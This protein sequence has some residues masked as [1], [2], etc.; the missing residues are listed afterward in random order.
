MKKGKWNKFVGV[1]LAVSMIMGMVFLP[2]HVPGALAG[3]EDQPLIQR[4]T[5]GALC[6][7]TGREITSNGVGLVSASPIAGGSGSANLTLNIPASASAVQAYLYWEGLDVQG[8]GDNQVTLDGHSITGTQLGDNAFVDTGNFAYAYQA[9]VTSYIVPGNHTY[10][11]GGLDSQSMVY[12]GA[13]LVVVYEDASAGHND[14]QIWA[15]DDLVNE[16]AFNSDDNPITL[17]FEPAAVDRTVHVTFV[18]GGLESSESAKVMYGTGTSAP[19]A[20]TQLATFVGSSEGD[21]WNNYSTSFTLPAG[22]TYATLTLK[23]NTSGS[24]FEWVAAHTSVQSPCPEVE[25]SKSLVTPTD[26]IAVVGEAIQFQIV[27]TNTGIT[28]L[29]TVPL[30]DTYDKNKISFQS[31][32]PAP[33]DTTDDGQLDWSNLGSLDPGQST[34][35]TLN[36]TA[37]GATWPGSTTNAALVSGATDQNNRTAP[38]ASD[39]ATVKVTQPSLTLSKELVSPSNGIANVGESVVFRITV[40]NSDDTTLTTVPLQDTYDSAKLSFQS[41]STSPDSTSSGQLDWDNVG[42]LTGGAS[43]VITVTFTAIASTLPG[44]TTNTASTHNVVD[45]NGDSVSDKTDSANVTITNP[46]YEMSKTLLSPSNGIAN[47]GESVVF[48]ITIHNTGDTT[49]S[50]VKVRDSY[51][52]TKLSFQSA[53]VTPD[54]TNDDGQLDWSNVG[55][56]SPGATKTIDLTFNA[57]AS[58]SST[59]NT[60]TVHDVVDNNGDTLPDRDD[61][62]SVKI[63]HPALTITKEL[64]TPSNGIATVGDAVQFR[65]TIQNTGDTVWQTVPLNDTYDTTYLTYQNSSPASDDN[66]DD[67][68]IDWSNVGPISVGGSKTILVNF[69]AKASTGQGHTTNVALVSGPTDENGDTVQDQEDTADVRVTNPG[70]QLSKVLVS[71]SNGIAT[72][73]ENV[74]F[75]IVI[76]NTGDTDITTLPVRDTYETT[77]LTYQ[78]ADPASDD[79][80]D[81]GQIDWSNVGPLAS[82]ASKTITVTFQ[83][84]A[85]TLPGNTVNNATSH[86]VVDENGAPVPDGSDTEPVTIT[87]PGVEVIKTLVTPASGQTLV[88]D[89]VTFQIV[90]RNTGDTTLTYLPLTDTY[91]PSCL[92]YIAKSASPNENGTGAGAIY[93]NDLTASFGQDL[94][95]GDSFTVTVPFDTVGSCHPATNTATVNGE[96]ENGDSVS[97]T[98]SADV[99]IVAP[100]SIGDYVWNDSN[101]NGLQDDAASLGINGVTVNL[102]NDANGSG[103]IDAG[104]SILSTTTTQNDGSGNP[105]WYKFTHLWPGDYIVQIDSSNFDSGK[106]LHGMELISGS[107]SGPEPY[108]KTL[109][110]GENHVNADFGYAGRGDISGVVYYDWDQSHSQGL[111]EDGI[112]NVQVCLYEDSNNNGSLDA[113]EPQLACQNTAS[114]GSY[115]FSNYLPGNYIVTET[116]PAGYDSTTPDEL[117][118]QLIVVGASGSAPNNNYGDVSYADLGDMTYVDTN[119]NGIQEA[120]ETHGVSAPITVTGHTVNGQD[121]TYTLNSDANGMYHVQDLI[122]GTYTVTVGSVPGYILTSNNPLVT[123]LEPGESDLSLDFGFLSPTGVQVA[124]FT[125]QAPASNEVILRWQTVSEEGIDGFRIMRALK[126]KGPWTQIGEVPSNAVGGAGNY[127]FTDT[128]VKPGKT[129]WYKLVSMPDGAEVGVTSVTVPNYVD[130]GAGGANKVFFPSVM[131]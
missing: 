56:L 25:V 28:T 130:P 109:S 91:D 73:G 57:I 51:D 92:A 87:N 131:R 4:F 112:P 124:S 90:I 120:G 97:D 126:A 50:T 129:Y 107:Q 6:L 105:G 61:D 47:V 78:G 116:N 95:P 75:H 23:P 13:S 81:D 21:Y 106:P 85:S 43:K 82:G 118:V 52:K 67:G 102:W 20:S 119:G 19:P 100:A 24:N 58:A 128:A 39:D 65:I 22:D 7:E 59:T 68:S 31:A 99:D 89:P 16:G 11:I 1:F 5:S 29:N 26:G 66:N 49:L 84:K 123:T 12:Q 37:V 54:D 44:N 110:E 46:S 71:P 63:T 33:G 77:Y 80:N 104:D 10:S 70:L 9:D 115:V 8:G 125:A 27:V 41:A 32:T 15:G 94:A 86:D 72:V 30:Q 17:Q 127:K 108:S 76:T 93:W 42:P 53:T 88:G 114:D 14:I 117:A 62:A 96:D 64:V 60:A 103:T 98:D 113:G 111:G 18:L 38:D 122:P 69:I 45:E 83:A 34:T 74:V 121:V 101:G 79:N 55:P 36:F 35:V 3:N 40:T 48:R 2:W